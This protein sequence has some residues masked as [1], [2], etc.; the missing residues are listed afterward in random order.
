MTKPMNGSCWPTSADLCDAAPASATDHQEPLRDVRNHGSYSWKRPCVS[1]VRPHPKGLV[2]FP[3]CWPCV[4]STIGTTFP[5]ARDDPEGAGGLA[6]DAA[7]ADASLPKPPVSRLLIKSIRFF[8]VMQSTG[9]RADLRH[10]SIRCERSHRQAC[11]PNF[12][13]PSCASSSFRSQ[14]SRP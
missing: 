4:L 13:G 6:P 11:G 2:R 7:A 10:N 8:T 9:A 12:G 5:T 3:I 1:M 14:P